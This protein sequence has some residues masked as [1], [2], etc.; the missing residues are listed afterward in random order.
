MKLRIMLRRLKFG[1]RALL[2]SVAPVNGEVSLVRS[3]SSLGTSAASLAS[4]GRAAHLPPPSPPSVIARSSV[5]AFAAAAAAASAAVTASSRALNAAAARAS[6]LRA[7]SA[8]TSRTRSTAASLAAC[9]ATAS[10]ASRSAP[11]C[12]FSSLSHRACASAAKLPCRTSRGAVASAARP[13]PAMPTRSAA[14][15]AA[16]LGAAVGGGVGAAAGGASLDS[17]LAVAARPAFFCFLDFF[18]RVCPLACSAASSDIDPSIA[19]SARAACSAC[20]ACG[21]TAAAG[22]RGSACRVDFAVLVRPWA[23]AC[24]AER[25]AEGD[26]GHRTEHYREHHPEH[27]YIYIPEHHP[28]PSERQHSAQVDVE[29]EAVQPWLST[30]SVSTLA[31]SRA[32]AHASC[33]WVGRVLQEDEHDGEVAV[34]CSSRERGEA[35]AGLQVDARALL[36]QLLRDL[37]LADGSSCVQQGYGSGLTVVSWSRADRVDRPSLAQPLDHL[38]QLALLGRLEDLEGQRGGRVHRGLASVR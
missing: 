23:L 21:V 6:T 1:M 32:C 33:P 11:C 15:T 9:T 25:A 7:F 31:R 19:A 22:C 37:Q 17:S 10:F 28:L 34:L 12:A 2:S 18:D 14:E 8:A 27:S 16:G 35:V 36:Q 13:P 29:A 3:H 4:D 26:R 24:R 30:N 20:N 38:L 5:S